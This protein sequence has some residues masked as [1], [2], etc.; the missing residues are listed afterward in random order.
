MIRRD[1]G[2]DDEI[3]ISRGDARLLENLILTGGALINGSGNNLNNKISGNGAA[4][5]LSGLDGND[6][7]S[8]G[9][10]GD[11][12]GGGN[13]LDR[14]NGGTGRDFMTGG[15]GADVFV[16]NSL[17]DSVADRRQCDVITDFAFSADKIDVSL[18]DAKQSSG[19]TL[20]DF[21]FIGGGA[22]RAEGQFCAIQSGGNTVL[23]FNTLGTSGSD[24]SMVLTGVMSN[25][26]SVS[27]FIL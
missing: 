4:N 8:G 24:M 1:G 18:I 26:L 17:L 2:H 13:G 11:T 20:E 16:F 19:T 7:L 25:T 9:A 5:N 23:Q 10:G 21:V 15:A 14:I 12:I 27:D 22:F 3:N 6:D